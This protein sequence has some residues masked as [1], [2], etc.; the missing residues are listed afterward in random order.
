[1]DYTP[2][3]QKPKSG[4]VGGFGTGLAVG[5]VAGGLGGLALEEGA[6]REEEKVA[7]RVENELDSRDNFSD[8]SN[9]HRVDY[10]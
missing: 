8:Y 10:R 6:K 7:E 2:Y 5:A 9:Y 4:K 1:M 3:D